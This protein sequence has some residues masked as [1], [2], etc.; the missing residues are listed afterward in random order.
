MNAIFAVQCQNPSHVSLVRAFFPC[1]TGGKR[2]RLYS[3]NGV[4]KRNVFITF[5][6]IV[7]VLTITVR[8]VGIRH[9]RYVN[10][11]NT[12]LDN[13]LLHRLALDTHAQ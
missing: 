4:D 8:S 7:N 2:K 3:R 11:P 12:H 13:F 10:R 5:E 9:I 6:E 1:S